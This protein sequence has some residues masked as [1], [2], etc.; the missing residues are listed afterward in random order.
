MRVI[1]YGG[2]WYGRHAE[3]IGLSLAEFE[4]A[5]ERDR[6]EKVHL[7]TV[8]DSI[9]ITEL[10]EGGARGADALAGRWASERGVKHVTFKADWFRYGRGAGGIRN[11]RMID[12][13]GPDAGVPFPGGSGTADMTRR[14]QN[15]GIP[16]L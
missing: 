1:V 6:R 3:E 2:R 12:E 11:Q 10:C 16:I 5:R 9:G 15:A 13:F 7:Y 14:L 8:L 4:I